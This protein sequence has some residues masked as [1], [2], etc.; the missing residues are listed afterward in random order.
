MTK[1]TKKKFEFDLG[2]FL[3]ITGALANVTIWIGAFVATEAE[4]PVGDWVRETL[5]PILGGVSGLAMGITVT[6][7]LV[8]VLARLSQLKP[9]LEQ[10]V[11]GTKKKYK[12]VA[13]PRFYTAWASIIL[14]L[15][16]SPAL[17]APYV[18]MIISGSQSIYLVLG[19]SWARA[20]SVGRIIAAD[21]A[22]SA[23][24]L[25]YGV[26]LHAL[27]GS[28]RP[29]HG[30]KP[31]AQSVASATHTPAQLPTTA[32]TP[33]GVQKCDVPPTTRNTIQISLSKKAFRQ[34]CRCLSIRWN[35]IVR[36]SPNHEGPAHIRRFIP[37][38]GSCHQHA[39]A[40]RA[41]ACGQDLHGSR[42]GGG[43]GQS[44]IALGGS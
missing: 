11:K 23:V 40:P 1:P 19:D 27:A 31:V 15:I 8:Y 13:N 6:V 29:A 38:P 33:T 5:L 30:A 4:G 41:P 24:A 43:D 44:R 28:R 7:G 35:R 20:W 37:A 9:T 3:L 10:K 2:L 12:S 14:L 21:L 32:S 36:K 17:L 16:I 39:P 42:H 22:M 26:Q 34:V 25:V 18:F